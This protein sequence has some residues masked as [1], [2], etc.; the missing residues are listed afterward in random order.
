AAYQLFVG[1]LHW[2]VDEY[3]AIGGGWGLVV[4]GGCAALTGYLTDKV[5]RRRVAAIASC[6]LGL[7]WIGFAQLEPYWAAH[8]LVKAFGIYAESCQAIW[9]TALIALCMDLTWPRIAGAQFSAY[10]AL[11]NFSTTLGY[12]FSARATSWLGYQGVYVL[13]GIIQVA[14]V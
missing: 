4:A 7:G 2:E 10:M 3:V 1:K 14:V 12:Q 8:R 5:G 6:M 11:S 9:V 13:G